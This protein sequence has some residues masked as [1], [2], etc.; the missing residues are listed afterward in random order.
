MINENITNT[1]GIYI[2]VTRDRKCYSLDNQITL[3][4]EL[5]QKAF[6]QIVN[7]EYYVE[8][9]SDSV[10]QPQLSEILCDAEDGKLQAVITFDLSRI[11]PLLSVSLKLV[12]LFH[13]A[14]VRFIS[15]RQGEYDTH[16]SKATY[17]LL[18]CF[19]KL[20]HQD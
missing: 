11:D 16:K 15:I 8:E 20:Q 6:G 1:V 9:G 14:K 10:T 7:V 18:S 19:S 2:R 13:E 12:E 17:N 3:G 5:A 4:T